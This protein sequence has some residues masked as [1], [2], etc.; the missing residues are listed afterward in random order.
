MIYKPSGVHCREF[1]LQ[2]AGYE[3]SHINGE[4]IGWGTCM[5]ASGARPLNKDDVIGKYWL[6]YHI[7]SYHGS[8]RACLRWEMSFLMWC[9]RLQVPEWKE[10]P[11]RCPQK[12]KRCRDCVMYI[13]YCADNDEVKAFIE[14]S[15]FFRQW[16][17]PFARAECIYGSVCGLESGWKKTARRL[18][19]SPKSLGGYGNCQLGDQ[20]SG[21]LG[22]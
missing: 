10:V 8:L 4:L 14:K 1:A 13:Y 17:I 5:T 2:A 22:G 3:D 9:R 11:I 15:R 18:L 7:S 19:G 21:Y 20:S 6:L 12:R 16:N